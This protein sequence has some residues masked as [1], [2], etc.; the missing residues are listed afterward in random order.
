V[1]LPIVLHHP[2][3]HPYLEHLADLAARPSTAP[4]TPWDVDGLVA[5]GVSIVHLHFGFEDV[6]AQQLRAWCGELHRRGI[7]LVHTV[8]DID[9]PHLADQRAHHDRLDILIG[10]A[11]AL[12]TLT[13]RANSELVARW[14]RCAT[15]VAHPPIAPWI[16]DDVR[17]RGQHHR[18]PVI[19]W[20]GALRTNIDL[21]AVCRL[22]GATSE[23]IDVV[24]RRDGWSAAAP[25]VRRR[26]ANAATDSALVT[27]RVI[28][29]PDDHRLVEFVS[30]ARTLV[31]P[32]A[33]GT[34]SGMVELAKD[35][36][37]AVLVPDVGCHAGQ[38][39]TVAP[40]SRLARALREC[41]PT[42]VDDAQRRREVGESQRAH[43]AVYST[44]A[45]NAA[46]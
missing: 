22:I 45:R 4:S 46:A 42:I 25:A 10:E 36:G 19:V 8:H 12:F 34:H 24:V 9:N 6:E 7:S 23:P 2:S 11:D 40:A 44:L 21:D 16:T 38:G 15:V 43:T 1:S 29:R 27:M 14:G 39:A 18:G 33:W 32:Y 28:D 31:L 30:R 35:V 41:E 13:D 20:L 37:T 3:D 5:C 17:T 26:L